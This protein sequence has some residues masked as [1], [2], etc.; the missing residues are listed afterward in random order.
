MDDINVS[1]SK[2]FVDGFVL[3]LIFGSSYLIR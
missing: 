2:T 1:V 3:M